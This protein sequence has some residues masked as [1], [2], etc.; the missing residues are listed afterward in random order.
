MKE[1]SE[2][3]GSPNIFYSIHFVTTRM[4]KADSQTEKQTLEVSN[5]T[6]LFYIIN[7]LYTYSN[8]EGDVPE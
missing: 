8:R 3:G 5:F 7:V 4:C 6:V 1:D 2:W